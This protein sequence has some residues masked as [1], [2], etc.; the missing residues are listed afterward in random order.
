MKLAFW[1][2]AQS[3]NLADMN[4]AYD[5]LEKA[6]EAA[7]LSFKRY[8]PKCFCRAYM[9]TSC[10]ADVMTSNLVETFNGYIILARNKHL[11]DMME[12]IRDQLMQRLVVKRKEMQQHI[13]LLC[14]RIQERLEKEKHE[15]AKCRVIPSSDTLF[16]VG[17]Y[18]GTVTVDLDVRKCTCRKW[19]V[20]G[21]PCFHAIACIFFCHGNAE[22]YVHESYTREM[23]LKTYSG[24]IPP[25]EGERHWPRINMPLDPPPIKVGPG[26]PRK[27]KVKDPHENPKKQG[28]LTRHGIEMTCSSCQRKG[29]NKRSWPNKGSTS[30]PAPPQPNRK[31][32]RPKSTGE[33]TISTVHMHESQVRHDNTVKPGRI[34]KG[35][36][37]ACTGRGRGRGAAAGSI[38]ASTSGKGRGRGWGKGRGRGGSRI[39]VLFGS[40]GS[41]MTNVMPMS[42]Q[43]VAG[44]SI[45]SNNNVSQGGSNQIIGS[46][47]STL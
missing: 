15:A 17:Y 8:N 20:N 27:N 36:K 46:Q 2:I 4:D 34:G 45:E 42:G 18:L 29:H 47:N 37:V 35:G 40:D 43:P 38:Q 24:T 19:D 31:R 25:L 23:Y 1:K 21:I 7:A 6:D 22:D 30:A 11:I 33:A 32:G 28:K 5:E 12:D 10:K 9:S 41:V 3:Y 16:E 44:S 39:G 13:G 14:P 26:R